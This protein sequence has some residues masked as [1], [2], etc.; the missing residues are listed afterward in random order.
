LSQ[1]EFEFDEKKQYWTFVK[2][3]DPLAKQNVIKWTVKYFEENLGKQIELDEFCKNS[4]IAEETFREAY[5][6][7]SEIG[8]QIKENS[9]EP[10]L[11]SFF[12]RTLL[13][14]QKQ[15]AL[16]IIKVGNAANFSVPGS[17]KTTIAYA[18][19]SSW[20]NDGIINKIFVVGPTS[21]FAPWEEEFKHCFG[22]P[23]VKLRLNKELVK[24]LEII[25]EKYELITCGYQFL[26]NY[27]FEIHKFLK[28]F[29]VVLIIDESHNIKN[30]SGGTWATASLRISPFATKRIILSGTPMPNDHR[31]LWTQITFL[32]P[33]VEPLGKQITYN[34]RVMNHGLGN[35]QQVINPLFCRIKKKDLDLP[36]P[37]KQPPISV[38]LGKYQQKIYDIIAAITLDEINNFRD[39]A[40]I[41]QFRMARM[42]RLLQAASNPSLLFEKAEEFEVGYPFEAKEIQIKDPNIVNLIQNYAT[43]GE[44]PS[45]L[46]YTK[47]LAEEILD[48]KHKVI[49]WT[50]FLNN[51]TVLENQLLK[52]KEPIV[53]HGGVPKEE[54][55]EDNREERI[56]EF[57]N[58]PNPRVIIATTPSLGES[59]SLHINEKGDEVCSKAI[60]VD[61]N[62][63]A[64]Q[65]MQ[66]MDRIHRIGMNP[67]TK[68]QYFRLMA[69][70]TIDEV[71]NSRLEDKRNAMY[72]ALNDDFTIL[73]Y[74]VNAKKVSKT[75]FE[76]DYQAVFEQ[77]RAQKNEDIDS[78]T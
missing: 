15:S 49:I 14:Y 29:K 9:S 56:R 36:D 35:Y 23:P 65:Y 26:S 31:D 13:P 63:N 50:S 27:L 44:I 41:Q 60:Y 47:K 37:E 30:P 32:W 5:S 8:L 67:K 1:A 3:S 78:K 70:G 28:K 48:S 22:R 38:P 24:E 2:K 76:K 18:A 46:V 55:V 11:P 64:G 19:I 61:R 21:S 74:D 58:D 69:T 52:K 54:D 71:I 43:F 7:A 17:G 68:V 6:K 12:K 73:D 4:L 10:N 77:L 20:I 39:L 75:E 53:I 25:G 40:R 51:I 66:S 59:V 34:E 72:D 57:K 62:F 45:K 33:S 42:I 16:H